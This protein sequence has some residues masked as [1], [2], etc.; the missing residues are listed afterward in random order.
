[1]NQHMIFGYT[2]EVFHEY[3]HPYI[4]PSYE[5]DSLSTPWLELENYMYHQICIFLCLGFQSQ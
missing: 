1:M 3:D 4:P 5:D 2:S